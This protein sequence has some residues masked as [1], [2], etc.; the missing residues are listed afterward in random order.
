MVNV[1]P[2]PKPIR[3]RLSVRLGVATSDEAQGE[4][5]RTVLEKAKTGL[6]AFNTVVNSRL[7]S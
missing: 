2:E 3:D 4:A 7:T 6:I 1:I 5:K